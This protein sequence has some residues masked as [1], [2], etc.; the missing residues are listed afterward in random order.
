MDGEREQTDAVKLDSGITFSDPGAN[1]T[2]F[3]FC[4]AVLLA[5]GCG[6]DPGLECDGAT[7]V[8]DLQGYFALCA[9]PGD[10][11]AVREA[12]GLFCVNRDGTDFGQDYIGPTLEFAPECSG[13]QP[14][15]CDNGEAPQCVFLPNCYASTI[16]DVRGQQ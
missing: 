6:S 13:G 5:A 16:D 1:M 11:D 3:L 2:R 12:G 14:A 7:P 4:V 8:C 10:N 15:T 9:E